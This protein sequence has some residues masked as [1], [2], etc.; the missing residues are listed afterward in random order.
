MSFNHAQH[1][2]SLDQSLD[3][4]NGDINVSFEFFLPVIPE[5]EQFTYNS[6]RR[7]EP[8]HPKFVL[9][10]YGANYEVRDRTPWRD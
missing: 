5:M 7:L 9:V 10:T 2:M 4:L 6:I 8:L 1:S 3:E